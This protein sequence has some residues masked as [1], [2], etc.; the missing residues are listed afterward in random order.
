[1]TAT[2]TSLVW[3]GA[4]ESG[5]RMTIRLSAIEEM[6]LSP[7]DAYVS[8]E[9]TP[10]MNDDGNPRTDPAR[11]SMQLSG[12][13]EYLNLTEETGNSIHEAWMRHLEHVGTVHLGAG[14]GLS[15]GR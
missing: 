2:S 13:K 10:L 3:R 1:M 14:G 11:W 8:I 12:G 6:V 7:A 9:G 4:W 15:S 5:R